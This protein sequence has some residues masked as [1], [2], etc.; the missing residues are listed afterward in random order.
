MYLPS[1]AEQAL[2]DLGNQ[3]RL[4]RKR[5]QWT[6]SELASKMSVSAPTVMAIEHGQP[7]VGM[8]ILFS[9]LWILGLEKE[10]FKLSHPDDQVGLELM[11]R[12][13]PKRIRQSIRKTDN[14]F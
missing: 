11:N 12:R 10:L 4:A 2:K 9:A 8:G 7:T 3:I 1:S 13:L 14:D 5:R 6:V